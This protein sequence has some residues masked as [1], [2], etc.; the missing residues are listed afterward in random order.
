[1]QG[2]VNGESEASRATGRVYVFE[3][4]EVVGEEGAHS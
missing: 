4:S 2:F 1:M 3:L